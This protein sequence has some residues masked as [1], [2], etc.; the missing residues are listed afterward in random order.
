VLDAP[1]GARAVTFE[2]GCARFE[3]EAGEQVRDLA[4]PTVDRLARPYLPV[5]GGIRLSLA[6]NNPLSM[7]EAH[8]DKT[9]NAIDLG[10]RAAEQWCAALR[11]A[12]DLVARHLPD[13]RGEMDL[14]VQQIVPVGF[15]RETHVSASYQEAIGTIYMS[16]H[17]SP[18]TMAEALVHE[19]SHNKLNALFEV[20]VVLENAFSPLFSSPV[21]PDPRPLHGVLLAAHAF[22]PV[23]RLYE[24]MIEEQHPWAEESDFRR[25]YRQIVEQ[26]HQSI[27][28]VFE[29]GEPTR[30]GRALVDELVRWNFH[31]QSMRATG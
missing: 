24:R 31:F 25:R 16:L 28:V 12:L 5:E 1:D 18:M 14:F 7:L 11:D 26:N 19:F 13:L 15:D 9:G 2:D 22:V 21:R 6:D 30:I 3:T 17:P 23:A 27:T 29:N 4:D 10:G 20:D 8:P